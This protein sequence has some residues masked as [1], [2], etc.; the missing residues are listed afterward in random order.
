MDEISKKTEGV[1]SPIRN[2]RVTNT[3]QASSSRMGSGSP[4]VRP[5]QPLSQVRPTA[6]G[7]R[8]QRESQNP[9]VSSMPRRSRNVVHG[10]R[11]TTI[12]DRVITMC[13]FML[14]LGLPVFFI[15]LTYQGINF[16]KQYYFYLWSFCGVVAMIARGMLGGK[17]DFHRTSLDIPLAILWLVALFSTIF[18]VDKYHSIFG[19]FDNP[20]SGLVSITA[21]IL[22]YYLIVT[23]LTKGRIMLMWWAI[24]IGGSIVTIWSFL[25]T[26]RFVPPFVLDHIVA[27]LTGSFTSLAIFLGMLLPVYVISLAIIV[28]DVGSSLRARFVAGAIYVL[29]ILDVLTL[30]TLHGYVRWPIILGAVAILLAFMISR[31]VRASQSISTIT[32]GV[33]LVLFGLMAWGQPIISRTA[34][35]S[36]AMIDYRLSMSIAMQAIK[37]RPIFGSG[38]STFGYN[39][40]LY[41]PKELNNNN[42]GQYDMRFFSD[43]GMVL[44]SISTMGILGAAILIVVFLTYISTVV[45]A[46]MR[47]KD[48][49]MKIVSLG[50]F[51]SSVVAVIYVLFWSV[52]G[53]IIL[54]GALVSALLVGVLRCGADGDAAESKITLSIATSPQYALSF[55]FVSILVAVGVIFGFVTLGKMFV[56]DIHAGS[57]LR[58]RAAGDYER[59]SM[60][61]KKAVLLNEKEGRY[62]T[63]ISQYGLDLANMEAAK[64]EGERND[65]NIRTYINGAASTASVGRELMPNDVLANE[66]KGFI[67]ENS[68]GYVEDDALHIA[69]DAYIK[70]SRLEPQNPYLDIAVGKLKLVEAESKGEAV[71]EKKSLINEAKTLFE[72][73]REKT[74]FEYGGRS[75]SKFA[76]AH[77]YISVVE[78]ALENDDAAIDAMATAL[79]VTAL[80]GGVS[81]QDQVISRQV[82]YGFNLAR[83]LQKRGSEDDLGLAERLLQEIMQVNDQDV[84]VHLSLGLLYERTDRKDQAVQEYKKILAIIPADADEKMR[85]NIQQLIDTVEQGGNNYEQA[86]DKENVSDD[87][88]DPVE[89]RSKEVEKPSVLIIKAK[90][91]DSAQTIQEALVDDGYS[92]EIRDED[93]RTHDGVVVMH[94]GNIDRDMLSDVEDSIKK[95][96]ATISTERNDQEANTYNHDIVIVVGGTNNEETEK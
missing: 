8:Q 78:E 10:D 76:P 69:I 38:P 26:M 79:Q 28:G 86:Q 48:E 93:E 44:E 32:V 39:F 16:E 85:E 45:H 72:T 49:E 65:D 90:D 58:A 92:V 5:S 63:V 35:Q 42:T 1:V 15:N 7:S 81:D 94:G 54:Y 91:G 17:I 9:N 22:A 61:F 31:A 88:N 80:N 13:V 2:I 95:V 52:D 23:H 89:A 11:S 87:Q 62:Y 67:F 33:F 96:Y 19:F 27:S 25:A 43:R 53:T 41:R 36:E 47:T 14:F 51:T 82:N 21:L 4:H 74:T 64:P 77:Y 50:L 59:S 75:F 60:L 24:T 66:T 6:H 84:N 55:A 18:S 3:A 34:I 56:A 30:S 20:V 40:S 83:L 57:A 73:A 37:E 68:G 46:F 70:A 12:L 71:E 29:M